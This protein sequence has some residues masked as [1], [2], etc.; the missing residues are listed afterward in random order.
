M[1]LNQ[2]LAMTL[3]SIAILI[4]SIGAAIAYQRAPSSVIGVFDFAYVGFAVLWG[5]LFFSD[6][7]D[8]ISFTGI[9]LIV[10][11]G[12]ISVLRQRS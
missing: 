10:I 3:L 8:I 6:Y 11:A 9:G 12:M 5:A 4:G 1:D 2:W 7:P